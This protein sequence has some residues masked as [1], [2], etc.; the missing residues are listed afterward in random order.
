V[1]TQG[2]LSV[3]VSE[4]AHDLVRK[5]VER[6][7]ATFTNRLVE[8]DAKLKQYQEQSPSASHDVAHWCPE[9]PSLA[10]DLALDSHETCPG[11]GTRDVNDGGSFYT[12]MKQPPGTTNGGTPGDLGRA[13]PADEAA[14]FDDLKYTP[15]EL[16]RFV[17]HVKTYIVGQLDILRAVLDAVNLG[18]DICS[19]NLNPG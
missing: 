1:G 14:D 13:Q 16:A 8:A 18:V 17:R 19:E 10:S 15:Q 6:S 4:M 11:H 9:M 3:E 12:Y 2:E 5:A 7:I